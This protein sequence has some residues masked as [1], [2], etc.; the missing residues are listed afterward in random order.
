MQKKVL[1]LEEENE[2]LK[3]KVEFQQI[4]FEKEK[5]DLIKTSEANC[6]NEIE[7]LKLVFFFFIY[8]FCFLINIFIKNNQKLNEAIQENLINQEL[9][10][11]AEEKL[12]DLTGHHNSKQK[13]N[14][15]NN[16]R[17]KIL[18]LE[19]V[20]NEKK[21]YNFITINKFELIN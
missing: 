12:I 11:K 20:K 6:K 3:K 8:F 1:S 10:T 2:S 15:V 21:K 16:L 13:I 17:E 5:I 9:R 7:D 14:Y 19:A 4:L 18:L